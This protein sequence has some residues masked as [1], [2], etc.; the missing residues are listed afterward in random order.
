MV[1]RPSGAGFS[2]KA[3][4]VAPFATQRSISLE[5]RAGSHI[6]IRTSGI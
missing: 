5:A 2:E 1:G 6:G 3:N 4:A